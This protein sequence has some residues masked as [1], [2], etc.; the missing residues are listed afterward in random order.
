ME[1]CPRMS[2]L[3]FEL[4]TCPESIDFSVVLKKV[5]SNQT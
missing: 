3:Y 2:M 1:A 4:K 5:Y